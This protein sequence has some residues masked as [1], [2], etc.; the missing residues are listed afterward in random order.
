MPLLLLY[1]ATAKAVRTHNENKDVPPEHFY[2]NSFVLIDVS[3]AI[4]AELLH[5]NCRAKL[6]IA[7]SQNAL[8]THRQQLAE[9]IN[10]IC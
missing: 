4:T 5:Y 2:N 7:F 8:I 6:T 10:R 3:T 9:S 1:I